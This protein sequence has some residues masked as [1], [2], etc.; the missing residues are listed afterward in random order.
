MKRAWLEYND[1]IGEEIRLLFQ[2]EVALTFCQHG[3]MA[4]L[5]SIREIIPRAGKETLIVLRNPED[6][7]LNDEGFFIF[8]RRPGQTLLRGFQGYIV[9]EGDDFFIISFPREI[10]KVQRRHHPRVFTPP[11]SSFS[12]SPSRSRRLL[13]GKVKNFSRE[14][15]LVE[16]DLAGL[17]RGQEISPLSLTL[18]LG[19]QQMEPV[20]VVIARARILRLEHKIED[21]W[22]ASLQFWHQDS[23]QRAIARYL[24]WRAIE[25][26]T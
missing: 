11:P 4:L 22:I 26:V 16:G 23:D 20:T 18:Y 6:F 1:D 12:M 19:N 8:Y 24:E 25:T 2:E 10:Y 15:V 5:S 3:G 13:F 7:A 21:V 17:E 9:Q 14:G